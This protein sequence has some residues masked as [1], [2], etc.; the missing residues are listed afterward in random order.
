M[1]DNP[2]VNEILELLNRLKGGIRACAA[3]EDHLGAE[4]RFQCA[5]E[6]KAYETANWQAQARLTE[7]TANAEAAWQAATAQGQARLEKSQERIA[8]AH[9]ASR[10]QALEKIE[11]WEGH[12]K[13]QVQ[14]SVM[15]TERR[16]END[17]ADAAV[18]W[19]EFNRKL[20]E[21][22]GAFVSLETAAQKAF[23]GYGAFRRWLS[24]YRVWPEA[25][26]PPDAPRLVEAL[27]GLEVKIRE[28]LDRF[29]QARLP[30]WFGYLSIWLLL[31]LLAIAGAGLIPVLHRFGVNTVTYRDAGLI[32]AA[33][34]GLLC[35][36]YG[37][38]YRQAKPAALRIAAGLAAARRH[39]EAGAT[40]AEAG[41]RQ[42][43]ERIKAEAERAKSELDR[44]WR[45]IVSQ[46]AEMREQSPPRI[47]AKA[48][49]VAQKHQQ[50]HQ[51]RRE[52]LAAQHTA[53]LARARLEAEAEQQRLAADHGAKLT[54]LETEYRA[55]WRT[56]EQ[57]WTDT[58]QPV[59]SALHKANAVAEELYPD[60]PNPGWDLWS[61][62]HEFKN[63][64]KFARLEVA[65][66]TFTDT[67][68]TKRRL[69]A[70]GPATFSVPLALTYPRQG[71]ILFE[72]SGD[73]DEE[74]VNAINNIV[75]RLLTTTPPGKLS[76]TIIDPVGLGQS[77][78]G[79]M[80]LADYEASAIN[81]RIWTQTQQIEEKLA[82]INQHME[83]VI[84]MYLRNEYPTIAEYNARAGVIAEKYQILVIAGFPV[85]FSETAGRRLLSIVASGGRCGVYT[86]IH[87][88]HRHA[89]PHD[90]TPDELRKNAVCVTGNEVGFSLAGSILPGVRLLLD[91]PPPP[92]L[93]TRLLRL[94]GR[95]GKDASRV[96]VPF[97]QIAPAD[98]EL[99]T[100]DATGELRVPIGLAG[101]GKL[102]YLALGKGTRQH[103]LIAGKTGSGKSTLFHIL[104]TNLALRCSPDQVEFYLVDFKKGVEFRCYATR[105]LPHARVVA[106]ESDR[107][108][109]LSVLQ[110]VDEELRRRGDLFRKLGVQDLPGYKKAGGGE[111]VPRCLLII[112]EFQEFFVEEDRIA[113]S[114]AMLLDRIVRQGRA[115]GIHVLLGSQT[116]GGAYTLARATLGQMVVR[117]AL[118]CNETDAFLIMD[119]HNPAPQLLSRPGEGIYNDTAGAIEGNSPFQA[120]WLSD[121]TRDGCLAKIRERAERSP[122]AY[123]GPMV[124]EGNAP[125]EVRDNAPLRAALAARAPGTAP[126]P[127]I[128][129]GAPNAIK[130][131]AEA[132]FRRQSGHHLLIVGQREEAALGILSLALVALAAQYPPRGAR[133][134]LLDRS[135][136]DSWQRV[137][138]ERFLHAI[139]NPVTQPKPHELGP[140]LN[141]LVAEMKR[142]AESAVAAPPPPVFLLIHSLEGYR[143]LRLEDDFSLAPGAGEGGASPAALLQSLIE[144]GSSQ[145]IHIVASCD[146]YNNVTRVLG[147]KALSEFALRVVFQMSANDS[148]NLIDAPDASAL[149]LHRALFYHE[150]DGYLETFRPYALPGKEWLEEA[151]RQLA[152]LAV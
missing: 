145:G 136:P 22:R 48:R 88:D 94:V 99:W 114:A 67:K 74:V 104:I 13:Y 142:R 44:Q 62:P 124:F 5:Q 138:L 31:L 123:P 151:A 23:R 115:F 102:Q 107:A 135:P 128:W 58:L 15:E 146:T 71:S 130:G 18:R 63:G 12:G 51:A 144:E 122:G 103:A 49:R 96:E 66:E 73:G 112:D 50:Q 106:I 45:E 54:G 95:A 133:F 3:R 36:V 32:L 33:P 141:D 89:L 126:L 148:A 97:A 16:R 137:V 27:A 40:M 87:W 121:E 9:R 98:A 41:L 19:E 72:T 134:I 56:L 113:Q 101:P 17:L 65:L 143:N 81:S 2:S 64:A 131:P 85:N 78:A 11:Q 152:R 6:T 140:I 91:A 90:F 129:L 34:L 46:G 60:W 93:A 84:Q 42:E 29:G 35:A 125:A 117:I 110:R 69:P 147:R 4:Y 25:G 7:A 150:R 1:S 57:E 20:E 149:G 52:R 61:P 116:L 77:F 100:D 21:S 70:P 80:H 132:V 26:P 109:G 55:R 30:R 79:L 111:R 8:Q 119:E 39:R 139:P 24:P 10:K 118:Q 86:L 83:K 59:W 75:F 47:E 92:A 105:Q 14:K 82:E 108:F 120:V 28:E 127:R 43:Q 38:G 37:Y 53:T 68:F 76:F